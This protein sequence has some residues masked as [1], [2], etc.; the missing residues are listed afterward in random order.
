MTEFF[1]DKG[2]PTIMHTDGAK[3]FTQGHWQE[4]LSQ[5]GGIKQTFAKPYSPWQ[6]QAEAGIQEHKKQVLRVLRRTR[7]SKCLWDYAAIYVSEVR[8]RTA[9]QMY[10]LH[11]R[12]PYEIVAGDTP[13]ITE[14][15]EYDFYQPYVYHRAVLVKQYTDPYNLGF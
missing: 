12:T 5:H 13:D 2:V 3:E 9:H 6:N 4:I 14:W 15:L 7:A 11:G 8:S 1:E 10:E